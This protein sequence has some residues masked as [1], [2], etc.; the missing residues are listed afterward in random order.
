MVFI[1]ENFKLYFLIR[2]SEEG[3]DLFEEVIYAL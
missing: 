2:N 3:K 1:L